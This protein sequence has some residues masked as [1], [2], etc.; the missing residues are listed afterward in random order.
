MMKFIFLLTV[1]AAI[2]YTVGFRDAQVNDR[3]IVVRMV[4]RVG[5]SNRQNFDNDLDRR[6][7]AASGESRRPGR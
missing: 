1:G 5:G 4:E 7:E 3:T 6:T 2:G